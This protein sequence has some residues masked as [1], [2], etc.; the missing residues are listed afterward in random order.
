MTKFQLRKL[1]QDVEYPNDL[2]M[3][4]GLIKMKEIDVE[5]EVR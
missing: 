2:K 5:N 1:T 3:Q 4:I